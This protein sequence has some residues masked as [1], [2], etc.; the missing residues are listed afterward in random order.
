LKQDGGLALSLLASESAASGPRMGYKAPY[1][2]TTSHSYSRLP[3]E[4]PVEDE[5]SDSDKN[6]CEEDIPHFLESTNLVLLHRLESLRFKSV[7]NLLL[8]IAALFYGGF[9]LVMFIITAM[10][11][12]ECGAVAEKADVVPATIQ[13]VKKPLVQTPT[14]VTPPPPPPRKFTSHPS[15]SGQHLSRLLA[16]LL[17]GGRSLAGDADIATC[18][19]PVSIWTFHVAEFTGTFA[20]SL[21]QTFALL[22]SPSPALGRWGRR[23]A[24]ATSLVDNPIS[25]KVSSILCLLFSPF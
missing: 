17:D 22:C 20:F 2:S 19:S 21:V 3:R 12:N 15:G 1:R 13:I 25:L 10:S 16:T 7:A 18:E 6:E 23:E 5:V 11:S 8:A 24:G 4:F 14:K 9:S